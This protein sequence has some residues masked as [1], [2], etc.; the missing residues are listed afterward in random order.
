M[1]SLIFIEKFYYVSQQWFCFFHTFSSLPF[2]IYVWC[3]ADVC[4]YVV[5]PESK[6]KTFCVIRSSSTKKQ[7]IKYIYVHTYECF[8]C[9]TSYKHDV[10]MFSRY[11]KSLCL[12]VFVTITF[13][14]HA[15]SVFPFLLVFFT[16]PKA[17]EKK[18]VPAWWHFL[19]HFYIYVYVLFLHICIFII[20]FRW[21]RNFLYGTPLL[22][23]QFLFL[24]APKNLVSLFTPH[25][26]NENE[27]QTEK[28][29]SG[30]KVGGDATQEKKISFFCI[31]RHRKKNESQTTNIC[32]KNDKRSSSQEVATAVPIFTSFPLLIHTNS[33]KRGENREV[34]ISKSCL[35]CKSNEKKCSTFFSLSIQYCFYFYFRLIY[36]ASSSTTTTFTTQKMEAETDNN[37]NNKTRGRIRKQSGKWGRHY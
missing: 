17:R 6:E 24:R 35:L 15:I 4:K 21:G 25:A 23:F 26:Q 32:K 12:F 10:R 37:G 8:T 3:E 30:G 2:S 7:E 34:A 11:W 5:S 22:L 36:Y 9:T 28:E 18:L 33:N 20:V 13:P 1:F 14:L 29:K 19:F 31:K 27:H 16:N